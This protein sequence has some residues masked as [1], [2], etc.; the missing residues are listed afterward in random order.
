M[1]SEP[2]IERPLSL[3]LFYAFCR[4]FFRLFNSIEVK[5]LDRVPASGPLIIACNHL[6]NSDPPALTS[7]LALVRLPNVIAKKELFSV[8]PIG[9]FLRRWGGIPVDRARA[10]G[11][12]GGAARLPGRA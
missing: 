12:P 6:S 8:W 7:S 11:G 5:G 2:D 3:L 4:I 1:P 9:W 10:G